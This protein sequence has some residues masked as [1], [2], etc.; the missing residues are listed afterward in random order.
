[1]MNYIL[2]KITRDDDKIYIGTTNTGRF[3]QRMWS[4]TY[5]D[6][7]RNHKFKVD[8]LEESDNYQ[9]IQDMETI[10]VHEMNTYKDGLNESIDGKN[11]HLNPRFTTLGY[12]HTEATK[13]KMRLAHKDF[14]GANNPFFNKHHKQETK[15]NWSKK[16]KGVQY[17]TKL[18][19]CDV[20]EILELYK[21][22][23]YIDGVGIVMRNG[24]KM[25][26]IQAFC[27][28]YHSQYN[29]TLQCIKKIITGETWQNVYKELQI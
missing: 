9:Y 4:H 11:A 7:F 13:E 6:R 28:K 20:I 25:S 21:S 29:V 26:Y 23:P 12:K 15:D 8:I 24:K 14:T 18:K 10:A 1:M 17:T 27:H 2:Y 16:R 3:K 22:K 5:S 19:E